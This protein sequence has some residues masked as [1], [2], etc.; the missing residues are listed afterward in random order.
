MFFVKEVLKRILGNI[1][2]GQRARKGHFLREI[3]KIDPSNKLLLDA[4]CGVGEYMFEIARRY[5][6]KGLVGVE[7]QK[8]KIDFMNERTNK[9]G[10][11]NL[12][13]VCKDLS[14][15]RLPPGKFDFCFCI[16]VLEHIENDKKVIANIFSSLRD[17]GLFLIHVPNL[18]VKRSFKEFRNYRQADHVR[19]G[20][21]LE[22]LINLLDDSGFRIL[23]T[24]YTI[25]HLV[26]LNW[27]IEKKN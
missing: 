3:E 1:D 9:L 16:D 8:E 24:K 12:C 10:Y 18:K 2:V 27:E 11:D 13:G 26:A 22:G 5:P 25:G 17:K 14:R 6:V 19:N 4:G 20:Y 23:S 7:I 21:D 15:D